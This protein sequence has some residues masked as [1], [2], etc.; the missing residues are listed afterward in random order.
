MRNL[1]HFSL[2][3][4]MLACAAT[5]TAAIGADDYYLPYSPDG[6]PFVV[7]SEAWTAD[8]LGNHRAVVKVTKARQQAVRV[9]LKWRRPDL[10][11]DTKLV[12]IV[13]AA[14]GD[15]VRNVKVLSLTAVQGDIVFQP[16][17]VPGKYYVYY[18]PYKFRA[19]Y[20]DARYGKP[21][22][23]YLPP[24]YAADAAWLARLP[25]ADKLPKAT[26]E[27]Y[28]SRTA[29]DFFSPMGTTATAEETRRLLAPHAESPVLVQ[30]DRVYAIR[31]TD[32]LP[33]RW[34]STG[35]RADFRGEAC[36]GEYYVW[37]VGVIAHKQ[38]ANN[39]RLKFSDFVDPASGHRI[40]A[41]SATCFNL[42]GTGWDGRPLSLRVDV[43]K[44]KVQALWCGLQVPADATPGDY[45]GTVTFSADGMAPQTL[46]TVIHVMDRLLAD[47]G[48]GD[49]WRLAR[50]RWLNSTI[51]I[52]N[53]P[54]APFN[55]MTVSGNQVKATDKLLTIDTCGLPSAIGING[56]Q[57]L[58]RPM[59]FVVET[60]R[61]ETT[62]RAND[63]HVTQVADGLVTWQSSST[64]DGLCFTLKGTME[65]DG[66]VD[67]KVS[68]SSESPVE[69]RDIRLVADYSPYAS[70]YFMGVGYGGGTRPTQLSWD[71]TGPYDS[72]WMGNALAGLH[73]EYRGGTYNGPL[74]NDYKPL[75]P[76]VWANGGKGR[77][78]VSGRDGSSATVVT[79]TGPTVIDSGG[80]TFEMAMLITPA[81][82][83]DTR[84]QFSQRYYHNLEK[85]FDKAAEDGA[86]IIN[87]HHSRDLNPYINY[88]FIV[89]DSLIGFINHEHQQGRKVKLYY[90]IR[91]LSNRC[92]EIYALKSLG[93]EILVGGAG[94][95]LPWL[96]EHLVDDYK[97]AW[98]TPLKGQGQDISLVIDG[99]SRWI[100][101][102]LEG[103][104]WML[105]NYK[106]DGLYMDDVAFD[107]DVMKRVR[108]IME[109]HRP[110]SL[111][112]LHSN[113]AYSI[114]PANQY[115]GFFPYVDRLWFG[116]SFQYD[117]LSPD[118]WFVT[119]SGIPFGVMAEMLQGGGNRWLGMVYGAS[120]RHSYLESS[121]TPTWK[122]WQKFGIEDAKMLGYWD[123]QCPVATDNVNVKATA[124][125]RA[126]R[127]LVAI[128]NF[129]DK[130]H[131]T[132][133]SIDWKA[134]GL[135]PEKATITAP[136]MDDYQPAASFKPGEAIPIKAKRGWLL[137]IE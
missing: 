109:R 29:F 41:D 104:R 119:F 92:A 64:Q 103:Y 130:D 16:K 9:V 21:W 6:V 135:D 34:V 75:P 3:L 105:D 39:V 10:R 107:R 26:V 46:K 83:V 43:P 42:G 7:A 25:K 128:G 33:W 99:F 86:N 20:G 118:Q 37:Q 122:L 62:F 52:D 68:V 53:H 87:I 74:L 8:Q 15:T 71:W 101:Y 55:A 85:G 133:L 115:T 123:E 1:K 136:Q 94:Y 60:S 131:T 63:L 84:K 114:G 79:S 82:P 11:P 57:V 134:L 40:L 50:L 24:H 77:V 61:G 98:Y 93:H 97:S 121:P 113:T 36:R 44:G 90:T 73:V 51:G 125:V 54:V 35:L 30:E 129:D 112:D 58:A 91:E 116:E 13:D 17:T 45:Q 137:W 124:F 132:K 31:L 117:K 38:A 78:T 100:N 108:K 2:A 96:C 126:G 22:N 49:L 127:T 76:A 14:T 106:I 59:A 32:R 66:Y 28:E 88:P 65:F 95:G 19:Q 72:Y 69:V 81:R 47:K 89:R 4:A 120:T 56:R 48:D 67:C 5:A 70:A 110:G 18:L 111:I 27:R 23:D 12:R 80:K 102:Y